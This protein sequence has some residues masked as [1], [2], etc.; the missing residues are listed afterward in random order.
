MHFLAP[1]VS[2]LFVQANIRYFFS[3]LGGSAWWGIM[4]TYTNMA[5]QA[6][7]TTSVS[8]AGE[9]TVSGPASM[10][11]ADVWNAVKLRL[12]AHTFPVDNDALYFVLTDKSVTIP[13]GFCTQ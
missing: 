10:S 1:R 5:G 3:N 4:S 9:T 13:N 6:I 7:S 2:T 12:D 11:D 8:V